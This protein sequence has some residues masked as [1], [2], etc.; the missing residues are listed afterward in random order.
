MPELRIGTSG[1]QYDHWRGIFYPQDLPKKNWFQHYAQS[2]DTVEINNTFYRLPQPRAFDAWRRQAPEGFCYALKLSRYGT[3][4]KRLKDPEKWI[5]NFTERAKRLRGALGPI[6]VQLPPNWDIDLQRLETFL[7]AAPADF[8]WCVEFR[9][10]RWL[11]DETYELLKRYRAALCIHDMIDDHPRVITASWTYLRFHGVRY[12][13]NYTAEALRR[14]A[15]QIA[16]YLNQGRDVF[17]YFNND[18]DG[19]AVRNAADLKKFVA[20]R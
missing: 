1:Y 9:D 11:T 10:A 17:A 3:H 20:R 19:H 16:D 14:Q 5:R 18:R 13:G 4:L 2:F 12:G 7:K 8:R 15:R 6:L